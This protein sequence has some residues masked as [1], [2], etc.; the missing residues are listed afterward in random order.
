MMMCVYVG[1]V[2]HGPATRPSLHWPEL[3]LAPSLTG[4]RLCSGGQR[5]PQVS[6]LI[7][8][9]WHAMV[10]E[11]CIG[12]LAFQSVFSSVISCCLH[13]FCEGEVR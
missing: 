3:S 11:C 7:L 10:S 5:M 2:F 1:A 9:T 13:Q 12:L 8:G 4:G 6:V